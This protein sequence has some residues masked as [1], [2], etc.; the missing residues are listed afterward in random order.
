MNGREDENRMVL[1][2]A[3]D[4]ARIVDEQG[5]HP[6]E[7]AYELARQREIDEEKEMNNKAERAAHEEAFKSWLHRQGDMSAKSVYV[8]TRRAFFDGAYYG[9]AKAIS[10]TSE[11]I[12]TKDDD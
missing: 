12:G 10:I 1:P 11:E 7:D 9:L 2:Y 6:E 5:E 3:D 4:D 8:L